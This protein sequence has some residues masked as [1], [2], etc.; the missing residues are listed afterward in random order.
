MEARLDELVLGFELLLH[1]VDQALLL[2]RDVRIQ[3]TLRDYVRDKARHEAQAQANRLLAL[4]EAAD[5]GLANHVP[6]ST[7]WSG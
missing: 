7:F 5:A 4:A 3:E 6:S 2:G 1:A